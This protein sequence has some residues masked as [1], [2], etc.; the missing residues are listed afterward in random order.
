L[1]HTAHGYWIDEAGLPDPA[2]PL[3]RSL[4]AD[5][6]IVGG[7]FTGM[8]TAWHLTEA[9]PDLKVVLLE[10]HRIGC[11]PSG[12]NGGFAD[13]MWVSF[14]RMSERYGTE[15]ALEVALASEESVDQIGE[16]C[17]AQGVDAWFRKSGYLGVSTSTAQDDSW[18]SNTD[19]IS[20]AGV[21]GAFE[22][23]DEQRVAE[24]CR[25]ARFRGGV[26]Y[27]DVATVQPARL[28]FGIRRALIGRGVALFE[29]SPVLRVDDAPGGVTATTAGGA[30]RAGS[31]VLAAGATLAGR[32]SPVRNNI[33]IASSHMV[34][35]EPVPEVLDEIGWTGGEAISDSRA[36]L[37]YFRTTPDGRIAFGWGGGR[38]AAGG[39]RFG[40][41]EIDREVVGQVAT[42]LREYFPALRGCE[43]EHAWG[44]PIDA[45]A[46]HLPHVVRLPSGRGFAAFGYTGNGV[47]PS[48]MVGR[49]LASLA[50]GRKDR[51]S[52]LAI[53]EPAGALTGVPPEPFRFVGATLIREAI[54]RKEAAES[55]GRPPGLF[56]SAVSAVPDLIGF[57]IGR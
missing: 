20:A 52:E 57:H 15:A 42:C 6:V 54:G 1:R 44:G 17:Q 11:G 51:Y 8:W 48:Q 34:I 9:D 14:A 19:A 4:D 18:R 2:A 12:R 39:R 13:S 56:A 55:E 16:F 43:L 31:V 38:I 41:A 29:N 22:E 5:V 21:P 32:G 7:G 37:N 27:A 33:T 46:T 24:V 40:R 35:T 50:I 28:S 49:S 23:L 3:D 36:L 45:S 53:V 10:S 47:G 26:F 30:V 25:S